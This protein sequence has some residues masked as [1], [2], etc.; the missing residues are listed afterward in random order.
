MDIPHSSKVVRGQRIPPWKRP[1]WDERRYWIGASPLLIAGAIG[2]YVYAFTQPDSEGGVL[3]FLLALVALGI[4]VGTLYANF[5]ADRTVA[6]PCPVCG[7]RGTWTPQAKPTECGEC[8]SGLKVDNDGTIREV[9]LDDNSGWEVVVDSETFETFKEDGHVTIVMPAICAVCGAPPTT[10]GKPKSETDLRSDDKVTNTTAEDLAAL[11]VPLCAQH[12]EQTPVSVDAY[13]GWLNIES[14]R[15]YRALLLSNGLPKHAPHAKIAV[16]ARPIVTPGQLEPLLCANCGAPLAVGEGD[17]T[18]CAACGHKAA[19]PEPYKLLRDA[20]RMSEQDAAQLTALAADIAK[21]PPPWKRVMMI[22]GY[23]VGGV[24]VAVM[25]IGA[26]VGAVLG[27]I[28]GSPLGEAGAKLF[29]ILGALLLGVVSIPYVGEIV[30]SMAVL[31][32]SG[33]ASD[34]INSSAPAYRYD[35]IAAGILYALGVVPIALAY[36]TQGNLKAITELQSKLAAHASVAGGALC[37]RHCGAALDVPPDAVVTR[38]LYCGADNLL[39]VPV[40]T[41]TSNRDDAKHL[42]ASVQDAVAQHERQRDD[43]AQ[44]TKGLL[45]LGVLLVP[46]VCVAGY[47]FHKILG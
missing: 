20:K 10:T 35:L 43:D 30:A 47:L 14:Y 21:P 4:G 39:T 34:I 42:D 2:W 46:Y 5:I 41:A 7:K 9:S 23:V 44:T 12:A 25:A 15:Y 33:A 38:C 16:A 26:I 1:N 40:E 18:T 3:G 6:A 27:V 37:C 32:S 29:A 11:A 8:W 19:L 13:L 45:I 28:A 22:V 36:R 31:H 17:D 24:T